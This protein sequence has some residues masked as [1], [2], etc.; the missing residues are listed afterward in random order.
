MKRTISLICCLLMLAALCV[1]CGYN[2]RVPEEDDLIVV[3]FSQLGS[4][5]DWRIANTRS[6]T[7]AL[8][9]ENG[10]ELI[11]DNAKQ[12]QENQ[13][14]AIRNFILQGVDIIVL[15][16]ASETGWENVL[17]EARSAGIPVIIVDREVSVS[18]ESLYISRIGSDFLREG[19]S[20]VT[21]LEEELAV[22]GRTNESINILHIKGTDGATAQIQ[23]SQAIEDGAQ[24]HDN[25][26]IVAQLDGEFTEAKG[27]EVVR[28]YLESNRDIDVIYSENDNMTF[29]AM[30]ALDEA[31]LTYGKDGDIIIISFDAVR[32][33]L[34]YCMEGRINLCV[35]C[36]PLHGSL[37]DELIKAYRAGE[38][39]PRITY[40]DETCFT[41]DSLTPELIDSR[42][43]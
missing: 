22:R 21:W 35:E 16:P 20:A 42:E 31:G 39:I 27:Y 3:G 6:I 37:L 24:A 15:A 1:G 36:N 11:L 18:N 7:E 38:D 9:E 23:R 19:R 13:L 30:R 41:S 43:Y 28:D 10:Y 2:E 34:Q 4:E 17:L 14:I 25:W 8:C 32:E 5:S 29:G 12:K 33:A 40:V 26:N